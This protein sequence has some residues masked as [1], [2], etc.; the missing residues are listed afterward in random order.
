MEGKDK[1]PLSQIEKFNR[2]YGIIEDEKTETVIPLNKSL[3]FENT[4]FFAFIKGVLVENGVL[5]VRV[6]KQQVFNEHKKRYDITFDCFG[7]DRVII[8]RQAEFPRNAVK[9][10]QLVKED[11][12]Y[13]EI[14]VKNFNDAEV[15]KQCKPIVVKKVKSL[16]VGA[17]AEQK[18]ERFLGKIIGNVDAIQKGRRATNEEDR[19]Q[20]FDFLL[21][22]VF[23]N[24]VS[25]QIKVDV[26]NHPKPY[27]SDDD[28]IQKFH[29][30]KKD[31]VYEIATSKWSGPSYFKTIG[32][33]IFPLIIQKILQDRT[34]KI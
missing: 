18:F 4:L 7:R 2:R 6:T 13:T 10:T 15:M 9:K 28:K 22:G 31:N 20:L 29:Y 5:D 3:G 8:L 19:V 24:G 33:P 12:P 11:S 21:S 30:R 17:K 16:T 1:G 32:L 26:K 25:F 14:L 23:D 34:S 27:W